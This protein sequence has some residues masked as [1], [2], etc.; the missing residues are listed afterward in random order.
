LPGTFFRWIFSNVRYRLRL[1]LVAG[2]WLLVTGGWLLADH[3]KF[4]VASRQRQ[5]TSDQ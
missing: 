4:V 5:V 3:L 2:Y 1:S